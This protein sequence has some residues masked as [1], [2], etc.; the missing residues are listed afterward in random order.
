MNLSDNTEAGMPGSWKAMRLGGVETVKQE[1]LMNM[2]I[3]LGKQPTTHNPQLTAKDSLSHSVMI[4]FFMTAKRQG[5]HPL[6]FF[7]TLFICDTATAKAGLYN[8]IC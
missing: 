5:Q 7:E 6:T 1:G 8:G 4:S 3:K 2:A